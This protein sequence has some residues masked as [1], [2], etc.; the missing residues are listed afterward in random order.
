MWCHIMIDYVKGLPTVTA[1]IVAKSPSYN[2]VLPTHVHRLVSG[3]VWSIGI[4]VVLLTVHT[5]TCE[6]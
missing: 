3:E 6:S 2:A 1:H 5:N 4:I